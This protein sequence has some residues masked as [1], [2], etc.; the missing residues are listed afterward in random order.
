MIEAFGPLGVPEVYKLEPMS[1][2]S[3]I[4]EFSPR[5]YIMSV[6]S[7]GI[8]KSRAYEVALNLLVCSCCTYDRIMNEW[9]VIGL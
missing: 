3:R 4:R 7:G 5:G 2:H 6:S 8:A 1:V 9:R